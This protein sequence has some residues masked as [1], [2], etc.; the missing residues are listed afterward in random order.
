MFTVDH[1]SPCVVELDNVLAAD[2]CE[3][4]VRKIDE[5]GPEI[6]TINTSQGVQ[7]QT[8]VRNNERV[9][10]DDVELAQQLFDAA[11]KQLPAEMRKRSIVGANERFRCYRYQPGMRFAPHADGSFERNESEKSFYT[12]LVY[13]NEG[14]TGGETNLFTQPELSIAPRRG[15]GLLFQ[16]P[17]VHE[18][19]EVTEGVKYVARTDIMYRRNS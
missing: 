15:R 5:L 17:I 3:S 8:D 11:R 19:A 4:P 6:A 1:D 16:H 10:F 12:F 18:G 14:F 13:L 7:V 2:E 9:I